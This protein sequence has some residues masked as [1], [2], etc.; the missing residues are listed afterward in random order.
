MGGGGLEKAVKNTT[1]GCPAKY[2]EV[3]R[4]GSDRCFDDRI[5]GGFKLGGLQVFQTRFEGDP[6]RA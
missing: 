5:G 4:G 2:W 3:N 6:R 1:F